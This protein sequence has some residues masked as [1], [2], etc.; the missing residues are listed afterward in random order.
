MRAAYYERT[1]AAADVLR[2]GD[3]PCAEPGDGEVRVRVHASG[4]NPSDVKKRQGRMPAPADYP[5]IIPHSDGAGVIEAA[6]P[7]V[8][9]Q[10][11][12]ERV[13]LWNAQWHRPFGTA[14]EFCVVPSNQAVRLPDGLGFAE[15]ACL[16]IPAETAWVAVMAGAP[17]PGKVVLVHGGAGAVGEI[18]VAIAAH[19]GAEV[20]ATVSTDEKAAIARA[21]GARTVVDRHTGDIVGA[22]MAASDGA[23]AEHIVD[24]DFG[25]NWRIDAAALAVNGTIAAFSAPSAPVFEID[26]Y[27]FAARAAHL[28]FVQVYLLPPAERAAAIAGL[29]RLLEDAALPV[30]VGARFALDRIVAAHE[31]QE[32]GAVVGN[33]VVE[34]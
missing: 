2:V 25:A 17:G 34:I 18:A 10:R 21:A 4:V 5:L 6:G 16:G 32:S 29:T 14:A 22:V 33:I 24:V 3:V 19:A 9:P 12:G 26:Y 30:R 8:P 7:G 23:G 27:A 15:G 11:L 13:W 28:R 20:V 31:A 1:G